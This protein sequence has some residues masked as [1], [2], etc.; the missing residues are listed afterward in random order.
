VLAAGHAVADDLA[1]VI[2]AGCVREQ[3]RG[4]A[5]EQS[6]EVGQRPVLPEEGVEVDV[7]REVRVADDPPGVVDPEGGAAP[8]AEG[9]EIDDLG[10]G[11]T[12]CPAERCQQQAERCPLATTGPGT[13]TALMS[14]SGCPAAA[15]SRRAAGYM[16][17]LFV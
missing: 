3:P 14:P 7:V 17:W 12:L 1:S 4:T 2:D 11:L 6:I 10:G 15:R 8:A 13:V 5:R 16:R 9:A